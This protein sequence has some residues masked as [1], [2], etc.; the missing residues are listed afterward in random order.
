MLAKETMMQTQ[1]QPQT[2]DQLQYPFPPN[3]TEYEAKLL[4]GLTAKE[5]IGTGMGFMVPMMLL[6]SLAGV[7]GGVIVGALVLLS[8]KKIDAFGGV[9]FPLY[10]V[11]RL[12]AARRQEVIELPL[13][14]GNSTSAVE[15]ES[16]DGMLM[17]LGEDGT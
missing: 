1:N 12:V 11:L 4:I 9:S 10:V 16:W 8:L 17:H 2:P 3:L 5:L 13:I 14:M 7:I 15:I 6:P